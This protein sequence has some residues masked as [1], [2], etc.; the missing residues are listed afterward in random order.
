VFRGQEQ[1]QAEVVV[2]DP[3]RGGGFRVYGLLRDQ[4]IDRGV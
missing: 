4:V 3:Q 2:Q 1:A